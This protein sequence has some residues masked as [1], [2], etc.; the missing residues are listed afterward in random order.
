MHAAADPWTT[1]ALPGLTP[2][3]GKD[4]DAAVLSAWQ[5]GE[6]TLSATRQARDELPGD[7]AVG[8]YVTAVA[9][10]PLADPP[11]YVQA[12]RDAGSTEL[13]LYHLGLASPARWPDLRAATEAAR[14]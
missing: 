12:L 7:V 1:G 3:A 11:A 2:A 5:P 14:S 13:H 10:Q 8:S 4:I 6:A 9:A